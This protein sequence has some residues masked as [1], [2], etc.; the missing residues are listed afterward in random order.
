MSWDR[1]KRAR[2][3]LICGL[4]LCLAP[5]AALAAI[6]VASSGPSA[7][8][9]PVGKKIDDNGQITL[10][11]GDTVTIL[12]QRGTRVLRGVGT[13][14][15]RQS[16]APNSSATFAALTR[17]R[18]SQRV[19]TG[20][21]RDPGPGQTIKSPNLWYVDISKPGT[22]CIV[23]TANV[24]LWRAASDR[25]ANYAFTPNS[26][27]SSTAAANG[28][29][30]FAA[31]SMVAAWDSARMPVVNG[32]SYRMA[33]QADGQITFAVLPAQATNPE[34]LAAS[35]IERGCTAQLELL[36]STLGGTMS[37]TAQ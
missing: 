18:A 13:I 33:G 21:V 9:Y 17:Q 29:V 31:G 27:P 8:A 19:R 5:G 7:S 12:D 23:D 30:T 16:A 25:A 37:G 35:L 20:A 10:R 14:S 34:S 6:V 24:R 1:P 11:A 22:K 28:T 4:A 32:A 15:L 2:F 26:G 36:T 3:A